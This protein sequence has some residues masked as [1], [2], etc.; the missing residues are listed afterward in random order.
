[1]SLVLKE[2]RKWISLP[3]PKICP[4]KSILCRPTHQWPWESC[5]WHPD[6]CIRNLHIC[7]TQ[8]QAMPLYSQGAF[9]KASGPSVTGLLVNCHMDIVAHGQIIWHFQFLLLANATAL[10]ALVAKKLSETIRSWLKLP[11]GISS[12]H[13]QI[14]Y[15]SP[16]GIYC[17]TNEAV[18]LFMD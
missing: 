3:L 12:W 7:A 17:Y 11:F 4:S 9:L 5:Q 1:M 16:S 2:E 13:Q 8:I 14:E 6:F 10:L 18:S 15:K